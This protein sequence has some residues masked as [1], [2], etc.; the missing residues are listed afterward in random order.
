MLLASWIRTCRTVLTD[1]A[2]QGVPRVGSDFAGLERSFD[3]HAVQTNLVS[4]RR[5]PKTGVFR[6]FAG[7]YA[8]FRRETAQ[9]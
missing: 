2:L 8:P 7:D 9:N 3:G 5:L 6:M 4:G 1:H